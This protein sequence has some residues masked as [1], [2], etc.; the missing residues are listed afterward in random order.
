MYLLLVFVIWT[1]A[2]MASDD[3]PLR[4]PAYHTATGERV[5]PLAVR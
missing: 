2:R 4:A 5:L 3:N 1:L